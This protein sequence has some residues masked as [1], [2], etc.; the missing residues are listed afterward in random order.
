MGRAKTVQSSFTSGE[1]DP[2]LFD[3][4][5]IKHYYNGG[6]RLRNVLCLPQGGV[7][8]RPG[9]VHQSESLHDLDTTDLSGSAITA[10]NGGTTS[11]LI[12][13][14]ETTEVLTTA[15]IG[16]T[17]PYIV[18]TINPPGA[19]GDFDRCYHDLIGL[20][21]TTGTSSE[22]KLVGSNT[23]ATGPWTDIAT[24]PTL[25][26]SAITVRVWAPTAYQY[27]AVIR[28]GSTDLTTAKA[29]IGE[30][31]MFQSP[32]DTDRATLAKFM[33]FE[34]SVDERYMVVLQPYTMSVYKAGVFQASFYAPYSAAELPA[35]TF[36]Q[37]LDTLLMFHKDHQPRAWQRRGADDVWHT[38]KWTFSNIPNHDYGDGAEPVWSATR[39]WPACGAFFQSRLWMA[40]G[41]RP[42]TVWATV[43]GNPHDMDKSGSLAT[44][45]MDNT[46]DA[47]SVVNFHAIHVGAHL[48]IFGEGGEYYVPVSEDTPVTQD[49]IVLR[50]NSGRGS[51]P[52]IRV[53]DI[54]GATV[55][56]Q[57]R[58]KALREFIFEET[59]AKYLTT[60]ISLL[61][62]HLVRTPADMDYRQ[63]TS[64][65]E[66]DYVLIVNGD[67]T[68]AVFCTLR[69]QNVGGF[70]LCETDGDFLAVGVD[71][72]DMYFFVKRNINGADRYFFEKFDDTVLVDAAVVDMALGAPAG[73]IDTHLDAE[74]CRVILDGAVQADITAD[75]AGLV[76]FARNAE[77]SYQ[78]GLAFPDVTANESAGDPWKDTGKEVWIRDMPMAPELPDGTVLDRKKRI[79]RCMADFYET[80]H[81]EI[82]NNLVPFQ[83]FG[84]GLLDQVAVPFTGK[85]HRKHLRGWSYEAQSSVTQSTPGQLTLRA[86]VKEVSV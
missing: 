66:A 67:G 46:A 75:S 86:L 60:N 3:R 41:A 53:F 35:V 45:A 6:D 38:Y 28:D 57:R 49:N 43:S 16:T 14:D 18:C 5:D 69:D 39:G 30:W 81:A 13:D 19:T 42:D 72:T 25:S 15:S 23:A 17:D 10:P 74:V 12:D 73:S 47:P 22:F 62:S 8:R 11:Q 21:L 76:T 70:S 54:D 4:T 80:T 37:N 27:F 26:T 59:K 71:D 63:S 9:L 2:L 58:G 32:A 51:K 78:V 24:L 7:R 40:G 52:N 64:T 50:R 44:R 85:K 33:P 61:S 20:R 1:L 31:R 55:F 34:F 36:T 65:E 82:N 77:D 84:S 79:V 56:L 29:A 68:L 48:Q 83:S